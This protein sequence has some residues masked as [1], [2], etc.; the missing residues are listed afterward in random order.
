MNGPGTMLHADGTRQQGMWKENKFQG[1]N[2]PGPAESSNT[3]PRRKWSKKA[4]DG[5]I[6]DNDKLYSFVQLRA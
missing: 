4:L 5:K 1:Q 2:Q 3:K 6:D